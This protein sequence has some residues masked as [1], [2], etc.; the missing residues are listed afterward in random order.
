M[1]INE[2]L[3]QRLGWPGKT[4]I[5]TPRDA[6]SRALVADLKKKVGSAIGRHAIDCDVQLGIIADHAINT[7]P[8]VAALVCYFSKPVSPS[9]LAET[10]R[11]AWNYC[12]AP[13][14]LTVEP[15]LV[16]GWT[17][18]EPPTTES[19]ESRI[20]HYAGTTDETSLMKFHWINL[21]SGHFLKEYS[22]RF[23]RD[24]CADR[25]L[26]Q[27]LATLRQA[28]LKA[29]LEEDTAHELI[30][31]LIFVQF[32]FDRK[33]TNGSPALSQR[34]LQS[35]YRQGVL[36]KP[37]GGLSS[38]LASHADTYRFFQW[39]DTVFNGDLFPAAGQPASVRRAAWKRESQ[40]VS[41]SHL[42]LLASFVE[43][44]MELGARQ[45]LLWR[46]YSFDV[47]PLEF[48]S[49]IYEQFVTQRGDATGAVYTPSQFVDLVLD[50]VLPW[51]GRKLN[52]RI[53]DP[54]CGSG[55][56]LVK[57]FQ[58]LIHRWKS[59]NRSIEIKPRD[60]REI[61]EQC[62]FGI[63][64]DP[65]AVRVASFSLYLAMCDE[66]DPRHYW[67][68][69]KFPPLRNRN[70]VASDFFSS[71]H[72]SAYDVIVGNA[73]WG[74]DTVTEESRKWAEGRW[75]IPS[76]D[77]GVLFLGKS[78]EL[79]TKKG[80]AAIIQ[81]AGSF[82]FN[83]AGPAQR[84]RKQFFS[85]ANVTQVINL[86]SLRFGLFRNAVSPSCVVSFHKGGMQPT[87][88]RYITPKPTRAP[89]DNFIIPVDPHDVNW[90]LASEASNDPLIWTVLTWGGRR[91]YALLR[92]LARMPTL[93]A[94]EKAG[95]II[96]RR[97]VSRGDRQRIDER[98][99]GRPYVESG[100][101]SEDLLH[102]DGARLPHNDDPATH[103]KDS[104]DLGAFTLPQLL[105]KQSWTRDTGR[106][107]AALVKN[108]AVFCTRSY[109][110][111]HSTS[112][113][114][115]QSAALALSSSVATYFLFLTSGRFASYR[116]EPNKRDLLSVPIPEGDLALPDRIESFALLDDIAFRAYGL[117]A[118]ESALVEDMVKTSIESFQGGCEWAY[119]RVIDQDFLRAY[120]EVLGAIL[121]ACL[122]TGRHIR[123]LIV[124]NGLAASIA[125]RI[126]MIKVDEGEGVSVTREEAA[127]PIAFSIID[128]ISKV[129]SQNESNGRLV[130]RRVARLYTQVDETGDASPVILLAKPDENRY[131]T[132]AEAV[133]DGD[134]IFADVLQWGK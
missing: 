132:R 105:V 15:H 27:N 14:L 113:V 33:D 126:V 117:T 61:L 59:A 40:M 67:T 68:Q 70:I 124:E 25:M 2:V 97:G 81:P 17:C 46:A 32:L 92:R 118:I 34:R 123:V 99:V 106:I 66:I 78:L 134:D 48:I 35:L 42:E 96:S 28:L 53:L 5:L 101:P 51:S 74:H 130:Y 1:T 63:D 72:T 54:A 24:G 103:S 57:A 29:N 22:P 95:T 30:A 111:I 133:R 76:E 128:S 82:L 44:D 71:T 39:L 12:K 13:L 10:H 77:I 3:E 19:P 90:V 115:L 121:S 107:R 26:L 50:E 36:S 37:Y 11:L 23:D 93:R 109:F 116:P 94:H 47:I 58:R 38:I 73:P 56:F 43:G 85:S 100:F 79:L 122:G 45:L 41:G 127:G 16:R 31:R 102:I 108:E 84:F 131:W 114:V 75:P 62:I 129:L 80:R 20:V 125:T 21:V 86:A 18:C 65:H 83:A 98:I 89:V 52:I 120:G 64:I 104:T 7:T 49:S 4:A 9:V 8:Q 110:S 6:G 60:L 91:D 88:I 87:A 112:G 69:V 55:I 119:Q